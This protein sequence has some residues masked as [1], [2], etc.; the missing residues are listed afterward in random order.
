MFVISERGINL[1][2]GQKARIALARAVYHNADIVLLDSPL[3]AVDSHVSAYLIERCILGTE[4]FGKKT[5]IL[6][7]HHLEVLPRA[8]LILVMEGGHIV[9]K[10]T[11]ADLVATPGLLQSLMEEFGSQYNNS[12]DTETKEAEDHG[13]KDLKASPQNRVTRGVPRGKLI[14]DEERN[15]GGVSWRIYMAYGRVMSKEW[16]FSISILALILGQASSVLNTLFLGFWSGQSISGFQQ[17]QYMGLYASVGAA[18]A[19][20]ALI[21]SYTMF[22]AGIRASFIMFDSGLKSVLRSPISFHDAT[23]VGRII[24]RLTKDVEKLDD[25]MCFQWYNMLV[26]LAAVFGTIF[27]VFYVFPL[28]GILFIPLTV[29]YIV[30]GK[31]ISKTSREI[32]RLDAVQKSFIYSAFG[33]QLDGLSTIRAFGFQQQFHRRL[34]TSADRQ[35]RSEYIN[36]VSRRW[37]VLR[38]DSLGTVLVL[39]IGLF[40]VAMR[41]EV[42]PVK[43]GVVLTYAIRTVLVFGLMVHYTIQVGQEMNT[44]ERVS[45]TFCIWETRTQLI[46]LFM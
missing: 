38:L 39:G 18:S 34:Q 16:W 3:A 40:G 8:D 32:T 2:G 11:Y 33:K 35:I 17:G 31:F 6:V 20:G 46:V 9:Q 42:D 7:T 30:V 14:M 12:R 27:L 25:R 29:I 22:I 5:R 23:P 4:G 28:L 37:L 41:N 24:H 1:S 45:A 44:A 10:G 43:L 21:A 36:L 19:L 15:T 26:N 13:N